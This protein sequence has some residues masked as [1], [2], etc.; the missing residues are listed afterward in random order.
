MTNE[1][2]KPA[3]PPSYVLDMENMIRKSGMAFLKI[4]KV[5]VTRFTVQ[6]V[7]QSGHCEIVVDN[8]AASSFSDIFALQG[9]LIPVSCTY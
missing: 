9:K 4:G 6:R 8:F 3:A 1:K 2:K 7:V 5:I